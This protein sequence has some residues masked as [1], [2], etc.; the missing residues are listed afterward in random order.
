MQTPPLGQIPH[1]LQ[2]AQP[3]CHRLSMSISICSVSP[4]PKLLGIAGN[5]CVM[6]DGAQ[7]G[8]ENAKRTFPTYATLSKHSIM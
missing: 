4:P 1:S 6:K 3:P 2:G 8:R 5:A 7:V